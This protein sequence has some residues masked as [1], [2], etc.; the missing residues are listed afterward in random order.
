MGIVSKTALIKA[1]THEVSSCIH[2]ILVIPVNAIAVVTYDT[3]NGDS[4]GECVG[5]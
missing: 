4:V 1:F 3:C 5:A 2:S